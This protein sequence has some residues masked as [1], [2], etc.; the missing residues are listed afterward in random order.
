MGPQPRRNTIIARVILLGW[1]I[2]NII[3]SIVSDKEKWIWIGYLTHWSAI[4]ALV[5]QVLI[6]LCSVKPE[7]IPQ[8]APEEQPN[9]LLRFV[10]VMYSVATTLE[11]A[12]ILLYWV[13]VYEGGPPLYKN[14]SMHGIIAV[15]L[16]IDGVLVSKI[17]V[18]LRHLLYV[19]LTTVI[20]SIWAIIHSLTDIGI[21]SGENNVGDPL[22]NSLDWQGSPVAALIVNLFAVLVLVPVMFMLLWLMSLYSPCFSFNGGS[23]KYISSNSK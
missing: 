10:W 2:G 22:Y 9:F 17:P 15:L 19:M 8:P 16:V 11:L 23:R 20:Y 12:I 1:T 14:F 3:D 4:F 7:L 6:L 21:V 5:Y 13:L 18:R